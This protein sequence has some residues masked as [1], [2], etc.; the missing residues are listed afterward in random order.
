VASALLNRI[1]VAPWIVGHVVLGHVRPKLLRTHMPVLP[2][3]EA[4]QALTQWAE[5]LEQII[6]GKA[7]GK[8][9]KA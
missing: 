1:S 4:R 3:D 2:L 7:T 8:S 6:A 9:I 5:L